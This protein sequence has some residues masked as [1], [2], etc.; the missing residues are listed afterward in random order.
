[1]PKHL[2]A[3]LPAVLAA[4]VGLLTVAPARADGPDHAAIYEQIKSLAGTW[5]GRM[6]D[7]LAGPP[8]AVRYQ[9]ASNGK[10]VVEFQNPGASF[11]MATV[12]YL[13]DGRLQATHY[14]AAGN[15]PAFRLDSKSTSELVLLEF[16]G[17]TGFDPDNDGH[18]HQ[19]E[20]RFIS[21]DRI[22]HRWFH[23]VGPKELGSTHWFLHR[24]VESPAGPSP[25]EPAPAPL[26]ET[27]PP[28][29]IAG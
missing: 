5:T 14:C 24:E 20:I 3:F 6:D 27:A 19:G 18:V 21:P 29:A 4:A 13:A 26:P 16:D 7:S 15:Q 22:E 11:E 10:S 2:R 28:P 23:Y 9:V 12:Y 1:M 8:V 25:P 17:G